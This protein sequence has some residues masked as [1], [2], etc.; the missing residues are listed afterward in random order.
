MGSS[1]RLRRV[2]AYWSATAFIYSVSALVAL[3]QAARTG[4]GMD[5]ARMAV[6]LVVAGIV[7]FYGLLR[8]SAW[9][10]LAHWKLA[11]AQAYYAV[12]YNM[13]LYM[14][15]GEL[16]GA[17]LIGLPIVIVF[18]A[19]VLRPHQ[20]MRLSLVAGVA[21]IASST[22]LVWF[23]PASHPAEVEL[24]HD[25]LAGI[26]IIS[27]AVINSELSRL[28]ARLVEAVATIRQLAT[29]D[30]LTRLSNRRHMQ[31][32]LEAEQERRSGLPGPVCV[33]LIDIDF[34]K[35][36][37]DQFGHAAGD[38]VLQAF[39][40]SASDCMRAGDT[41]AR[42][43]GEEFLLLMPD[44]SLEAAVQSLERIRGVVAALRF[45]SI[46]PQLRL[47]FSAGVAAAG[48]PD[49]RFGAAV[50]RADDAMYQAKANGR[51]RIVTA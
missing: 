4:E 28:R 14:A 11:L 16:R 29:T 46:D 20:T 10:G 23:R 1:P 15:L 33:A 26:G 27:V 50:K 47:S 34:F 42:W 8:C 32:L 6:A 2:M 17:I 48:L 18:C 43:G 35:R 7:L 45:D 22:A 36:I 5:A 44:T 24:V 41:L 37:N 9:L 39:A 51:D 30:E 21:L 49:A 38:A 13:V 19:F 3:R 40:A 25:F 12:F 31:T